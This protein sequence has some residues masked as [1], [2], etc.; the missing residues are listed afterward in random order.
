MSLLSTVHD[1]VILCEEQNWFEEA[2]LLAIIELL[3]LEKSGSASEITNERK[4]KI[5]KLMQ[6]QGKVANEIVFDPSA[7]LRRAKSLVE[8]GV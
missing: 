3:M 2:E 8:G 5:V 7:I 4:D 6:Q 1:L